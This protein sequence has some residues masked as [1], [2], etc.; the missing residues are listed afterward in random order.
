V[1]FLTDYDQLD[2]LPRTV[3]QSSWLQV[4]LKWTVDLVAWADGRF[5][6]NAPLLRGPADIAAGV[7]RA[8]RF[9]MDFFDHPEEVG[10]LLRLCADARNQVMAAIL[11]VIQPFHGGIAAGGYPSR[12]WAPGRIC[13]YQQEDAAAVLS[14]RIFKQVLMPLETFTP[15]LWPPQVGAGVAALAQVRYIHLH[16]ACTYPVDIRLEDP[17]CPV[18]QV[19]YDRA[20]AGPRLPQ[21]IPVLKKI[22]GR[23]PLILWG[24]FTPAEL[25]V[26]VTTLGSRGLS[27]Q[28]V[29]ATEAEAAALRDVFLKIRGADY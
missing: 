14:P 1:P 29:A 19:N 24:E 13:L 18:L 9:V 25:E 10:E 27:I 21:L 8:D 16:S 28:P 4:L 15:R 22:A 2:V 3:S 6:V 17:S 26:L 5:P 23:K 12:L 7:R 11:A 20:G